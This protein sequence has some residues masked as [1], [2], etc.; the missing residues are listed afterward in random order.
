MPLSNQIKNQHLL[1]RAGFGPAVEQLADLRDFTPKDFYKA[2]KKASDKKPVY[3]NVAG[4][5]L[6]G[7]VMGVGEAGKMQR[8]DLTQE[9]RKNIQRKNRE[10][11]RNLNL[12]WLKEMIN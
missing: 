4:N 10:G 11:V 1:W 6:E 2:L 9:E 7:L 5:Y 8:K 12:T 3:I